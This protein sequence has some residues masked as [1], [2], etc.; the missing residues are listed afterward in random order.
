MI[1]QCAGCSKFIQGTSKD[2]IITGKLLGWKNYHDAC[3]K[4]EW[5]RLG[6][7]GKKKVRPEPIVSLSP[8]SSGINPAVTQEEAVI[9]PKSAKK[10]Q[11]HVQCVLM[12]NGKEESRWH[13]ILDT[14]DEAEKYC[15]VQ[16]AISDFDKQWDQAGETVSPGQLLRN[17]CY[18][19]NMLT[20]VVVAW[21]EL[22]AETKAE[23]ELMAASEPL[24]HPAKK[25]SKSSKPKYSKPLVCNVSSLKYVNCTV[26]MMMTNGKSTVIDERVHPMALDPACDGVEDTVACPA[27][28]TSGL[29]E[30]GASADDSSEHPT[31]V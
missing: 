22:S 23:W 27:P 17:E 14:L 25:D 11:F 29:S 7:S 9:V 20:G 30:G 8:A 19:L 13:N 15:N 16:M 1:S 3:A 18:R 26:S 6:R 31:F 2:P 12:T 10:T 5:A 24:L 28:D 4:H 21:S